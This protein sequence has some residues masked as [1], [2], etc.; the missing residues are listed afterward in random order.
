MMVNV[1]GTVPTRGSRVGVTR[2]CSEGLVPVAH[3]IPGGSFTR[4]LGAVTGVDSCLRRSSGP[5][6]SE[7][8]QLGAVAS[9]YSLGSTPERLPGPHERCAHSAHS[10]QAL[11]CS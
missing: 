6:W 7:Q 2:T 1:G 11:R 5:C 10:R 3:S 8:S 9:H 4:P